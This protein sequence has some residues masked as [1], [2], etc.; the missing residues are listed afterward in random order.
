MKSPENSFSTDNFALSAYLLSEGCRL[1]TAD[2]TNPKRVV[3]VFEE[4]DPRVS[5]TEKFLSH[6]AQVEPHRFFSAQRD[7]KQM[8][9]QDE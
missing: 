2:K 4:S 9:Y 6:Q 8:I 1:I 5:L 7:L 3:F